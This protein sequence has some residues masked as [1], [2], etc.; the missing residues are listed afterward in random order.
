M[1]ITKVEV[2]PL[3]YMK[4]YPPIPRFF[5][6]FRVETDAGHVGYGEAST[7]YGNFY[8]TIMKAIVDEA[9]ASWYGLESLRRE[10]AESLD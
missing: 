5:G 3:S 9:L 10:S 1:K 8:P 4:D 7:S 2:I 6:L